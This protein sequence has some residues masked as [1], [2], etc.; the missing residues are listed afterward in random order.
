MSK[1]YRTPQAPKIRNFVAKEMLD[2]KGPYAPK[3]FDDRTK[4]PYRKPK[5]K[6]KAFDDGLD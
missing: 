1:K 2:R 5:H 4:E 3:V 6:K